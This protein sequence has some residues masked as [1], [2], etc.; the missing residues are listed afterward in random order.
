[1]CAFDLRTP[2]K[3]DELKNKLCANGLIV[4]GC[5]ATTIR[6]RPPLIISEAEIDKAL[7]ILDETLKTF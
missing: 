6:F 3:R 2:E 5:G 4:L 1:M 7:E